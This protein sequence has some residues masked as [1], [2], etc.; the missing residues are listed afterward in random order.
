MEQLGPERQSECV[1]LANCRRQSQICADEVLA[2]RGTLGSGRTVEQERKRLVATMPEGGK[3]KP[4]RCRCRLG[5]G[6]IFLPIE[7]TALESPR[8]SG[9]MRHFIEV[10]AWVPPE[11]SRWQLA[12]SLS[13]S[14]TRM[15]SRWQRNVS[16]IA[17]NSPPSDVSLRAPGSGGPGSQRRRGRGIRHPRR[18]RRQARTRAGCGRAARSREEARKRRARGRKGQLEAAP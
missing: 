13:R 2:R 17:G 9:T 1:T 6:F 14:R 10:A 15:S 12:W 18:R 8:G 7:H 4:S 3:E 5:S 16:T 11:D